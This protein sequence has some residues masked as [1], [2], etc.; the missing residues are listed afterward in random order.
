MTCTELWVEDDFE[1]VAVEGKGMDPK[2]TWGIIGIYRTVSEDVLVI[3]ILAA[4][5][6]LARNLPKRR[7]KGG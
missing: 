1:M 7:F 5:N 4:S 2:Y 6:L 3:G